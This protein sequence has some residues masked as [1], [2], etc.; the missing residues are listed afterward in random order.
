MNRIDPLAPV[1]DLEDDD[2]KRGVLNLVNRGFIPTSAD[3]SLA[4]THGDGII[5]NRCAGTH[6]V[7]TYTASVASYDCTTGPNSPSSPSPT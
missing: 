7:R 3:L 6:H 1:P 5:Q 2:A 4:F